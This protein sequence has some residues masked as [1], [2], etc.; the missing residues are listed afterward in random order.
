MPHELISW[1]VVALGDVA[2]RKRHRKGASEVGL[3]WPTDSQDSAGAMAGST[4]S[5]YA[6][7]MLFCRY[8]AS[9]FEDEV[10]GLEIVGVWFRILLPRQV[11]HG[12]NV[13]LLLQTT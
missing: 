1:T 11:R 12:G 13:R 7:P 6:A 9:H 8:Q 3:L 5:D 10:G 4:R 2:A